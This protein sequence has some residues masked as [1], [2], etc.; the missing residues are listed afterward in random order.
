MAERDMWEEVKSDLAR[1]AYRGMASV[2]L[3]YQDFLTGGQM[4][5]HIA[6]LSPVEIAG[7]ELDEPNPEP[8]PDNDIDIEK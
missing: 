7:E 1:E 2:Q 4:H 6:G 8:E 5:N 3:A